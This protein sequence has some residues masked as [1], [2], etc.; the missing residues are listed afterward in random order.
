[1]GAM[2]EEQQASNEELQSTNEELQSTNEELETSKE[3][4]QSVNEELVTVN[5]ELHSKVE[6]LTSMQDDMKNLLDNISVGAIFLDRDLMIR[7]FTHD[8]TSVYRLVATDLGRPLTDIRSELKDVDLL[9]D[10]RSV[11]DTLTPIEREVQAGNT[12]YL[13]RTQPYRTMDNVIDGVVLTFND[14]TE[15]VQ[16]IAARRARDLAE[17]V[18][19]TVREPLVVLDRQ[20]HIVTA[21]RAYWSHFGGDPAGDVGHSLYAT[22]AG[23]WDFDTMREWLEAMNSPERTFKALELV[24][25]FPALGQQRLKISLR[26]VSEK[27][28]Q[29][30][31]VLLS[32]QVL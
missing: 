18:V 13:A 29:T 2:V 28:G 23:Q 7:R 8:A 12:W 1:M 21:N 9:A 11:L 20:L 15:R 19:D 25:V 6:L 17:A 27:G 3:E 14:V 30:D 31:L 26:R 22:G 24:H 4:L 5:S 10:A 32:I 16:A